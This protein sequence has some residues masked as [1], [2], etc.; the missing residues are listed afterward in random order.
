ML[1]NTPAHRAATLAL[2]YANDARALGDVHAQHTYEAFARSLSSMQIPS[3]AEA[4][5]VAH[6][7]AETAS[8]ES[9]RQAH[10]GDAA[11]ARASRSAAGALVWLAEALREIDS[12]LTPV[13][14]LLDEASGL[15]K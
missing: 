1:E 13:R 3:L 9:Q 5:R 6:L 2:E 4:S 12:E 14:H 7:W 8:W 11:K 10:K 15:W